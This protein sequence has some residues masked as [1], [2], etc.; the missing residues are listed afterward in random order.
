MDFVRDGSFHPS[1]VAL[2]TLLAPPVE[3]SVAELLSSLESILDC[4]ESPKRWLKKCMIAFCKELGEN[5]T[6][7]FAAL[8]CARRGE[9]L[10]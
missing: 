3:R 4:N 5:W 6:V 2:T 1:Y 7:M 9:D 8:C 10:K